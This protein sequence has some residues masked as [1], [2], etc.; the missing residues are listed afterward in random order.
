M[1]PS[2]T[3]ATAA[4]TPSGHKDR[5]WLHL[6]LFV[7]TFASTIYVGGMMAGRQLIYDEVGWWAYV[8]DGLRY[9][10]SLLGFLTV[11]EFGH[12]FAARK[13]RISTTLPYYIPLP[14]SLI[15]TLGAV[16]RIR[17]PIPSERKLFDV[18]AAG[19]LAGFVVA[20]GILIWALAT[21]PDPS[22]L[23]SQP[24][25]AEIKAFI[26]QYGRFPE[27]LLSPTEE[28]PA[29]LVV[30]F[31][32]TLL[33]SAL[34]SLFPNVPP[35]Y[36]MIHYPYLMAGWLGLFFTALNLLPVGQLD[37]GHITYALLGRKWHGRVARLFLLLLLLSGSLGFI[38]EA[39]PYLASWHPLL[40]PGTWFV[41]AAILYFFL[42][43]VFD[44]EERLVVSGLLVLIGLTALGVVLEW[45][46]A[47]YGYSAW[48]I[49]SL[50]I[51]YLIRIDH[52]PVLYRE[53]LTP[54]RRWLG[55]LSMAI[56]VL[57]FSFQPIKVL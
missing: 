8:L 49:W 34:A 44:G 43:R 21:L 24:G 4:G 12:Y 46:A 22:Y 3:T 28:N 33:F 47:R 2:T 23:M 6:L 54:T 14:I 7:A 56:F 51:I 50:L 42:N 11:H 37:G 13:H 32:D 16:I 35:D 18:G 17:E 26:E 20:L 39:Q 57:C 19:P 52:P 53:P 36:E 38:V 29:L 45:P 25:H 27:Q 41:L 30:A 5:Y 40:G 10:A 9:G 48:F 55:Y 31:G 1:E 15:G